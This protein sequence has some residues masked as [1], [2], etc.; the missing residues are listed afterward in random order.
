VLIS[1]LK[2]RFIC[3]SLCKNVH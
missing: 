1:I 3:L 2:N